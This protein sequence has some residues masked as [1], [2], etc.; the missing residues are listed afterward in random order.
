VKKLALFLAVLLSVSVAVPAVANEKPRKP[1]GSKSVTL[2]QA[3]FMALM[4]MATRPDPAPIVLPGSDGKPGSSGLPGQKGDK[5]D[6]GLPGVGQRGEVGAAGADGASGA[7]GAAGRDGT[8]GRDGAD[9][10]GFTAGAVLL[11]VGGCPAGMSVQ[12]TPEEW[13]LYN[14]T[15]AGRPWTSGAWMQQ[16]VTLCVVD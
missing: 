16:T 5:G 9:G 2:T 13:A 14:V 3:Q 6:P 4:Q 15:T 8:D 12:G 11:A 1:K 10:K 7:D